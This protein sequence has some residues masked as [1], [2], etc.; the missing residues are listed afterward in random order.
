MQG[1]DLSTRLARAL[2][3]NTIKTQK[4]NAVEIVSTGRQKPLTR[5]GGERIVRKVPRGL[6]NS[7]PPET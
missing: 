3:V 6:R 2:V 4:I 5:I 7:K 1:Y